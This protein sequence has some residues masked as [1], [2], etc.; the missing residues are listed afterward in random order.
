MF[1]FIYVLGDDLCKML[2]DPCMYT[3]AESFSESNTGIIGLWHVKDETV[4]GV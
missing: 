4:S 3:G 1:V 2:L